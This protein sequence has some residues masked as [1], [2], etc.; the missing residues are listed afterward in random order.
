MEGSGLVRQL[1]IVEERKG[2]ADDKAGVVKEK[3]SNIKILIKV[4][5]ERD[6]T[7]TDLLFDHA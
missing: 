7:L 1:A 2:E 3:H 5:E 4:L 6:K